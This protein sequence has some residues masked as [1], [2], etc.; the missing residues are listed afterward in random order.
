[1]SEEQTSCDTPSEFNVSY[2]THTY[3]GHE[4]TTVVS[5]DPAQAVKFV[6]DGHEFLTLAEVIKEAKENPIVEEPVAEEATTPA[7]QPSAG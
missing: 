6:M 4:I 1:M 2:V 7:E 3:H 5:S